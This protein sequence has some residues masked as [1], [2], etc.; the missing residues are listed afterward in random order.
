MSKKEKLR[1]ARKRESEK[2]GMP[3]NDGKGTIIMVHPDEDFNEVSARY[4][5]RMERR[6]MNNSMG[7]ITN[8]SKVR[9]GLV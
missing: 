9:G 1:L 2:I 4:E 3:V 7:N 6:N 8:K 5:E